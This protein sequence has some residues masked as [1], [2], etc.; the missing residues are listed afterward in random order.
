MAK[1][2]KF[3]VDVGDIKTS[4][5]R[6]DTCIMSGEFDRDDNTVKVSMVFS[7]PFKK[8][9]EEIFGDVGDIV[10]FSVVRNA[11]T[12]LDDHNGE[13]DPTH[14]ETLEVKEDPTPEE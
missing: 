4:K 14:E 11:Q 8:T 7:A 3:E 5:V 9:F 13:E 1:R 2:I 6:N 12:T 10:T